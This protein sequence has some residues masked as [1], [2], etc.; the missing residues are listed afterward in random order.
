MRKITE[1]DWYGNDGR[2]YPAPGTVETAKCGVCGTKMNVERNRL[3]PT[4]MAE[5]MA[6]KK[7]RY[8]RFTCPYLNMSWHRKIYY[9]KMKVY[10]EETNAARYGV[11]D[12]DEEVRK[13][14]GKE[15]RKILKT[16]IGSPRHSKPKSPKE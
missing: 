12:I 15:I 3:G 4:G 8:D 14:V 11:S 1:I 9:I 13:N 7:H 2:C 5:A 10:L 16:N 6:G